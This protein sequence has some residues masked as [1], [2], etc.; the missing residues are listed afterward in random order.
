MTPGNR[1]SPTVFA[2]PIERSVYHSHLGPSSDDAPT[3]AAVW[4]QIETHTGLALTQF[5]DFVRACRLRFNF[6][7]PPQISGDSHDERI[8][9]KQFDELHKA[10]A[11]WLTNNPAGEFLDRRY[12]LSAIGFNTFRF[13]LVQRFPAPDIPYARNSESAVQI[14][15]LL[16][17]VSGGYV[18]ITG[19]AR[20]GKSTLVQ[21]V[22]SDYP[23]LEVL[24]FTTR[25]TLTLSVKDGSLRSNLL[26][27]DKTGSLE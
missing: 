14:E 9:R 6:P 25:S 26:P 4:K 3:A 15:K 20:I 23:S 7:Q 2:M 22:L 5:G 24:S 18:A 8:Y 27:R 11:T 13:G 12:I 1:R 19:P 21:D 16:D 10:I 17:A